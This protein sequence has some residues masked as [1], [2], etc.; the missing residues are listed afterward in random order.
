MCSGV[1]LTFCVV[2]WCFNCKYSKQDFFCLRLNL[3]AFGHSHGSIPC[4]CGVLP[5][6]QLPSCSTDVPVSGTRSVS[7]LSANL[8]L[9]RDPNHPV[10]ALKLSFFLRFILIISCNIH[11]VPP[12]CPP[13]GFL[14]KSICAF[15][16][17]LSDAHYVPRTHQHIVWCRVPIRAAAI[18]IIMDYLVLCSSLKKSIFHHSLCRSTRFLS[19]SSSR[20]LYPGPPP[21]FLQIFKICVFVYTHTHTHTHTHIYIYIRFFSP[22]VFLVMKRI[23]LW[24]Q[25]S[26]FPPFIIWN[27]WSMWLNTGVKTATEGHPKTVVFSY[28]KSVITTWRMSELDR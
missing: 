6:W 28:L 13:S 18:I 16:S 23:R 22:V 8:R 3:I 21:L 19:C 27:C 2:L 25:S 14:P 7:T 5:R 15:I 26:H 20:I 1:S 17:H 12:V 11:L 24:N 10:S 9:D 4:I